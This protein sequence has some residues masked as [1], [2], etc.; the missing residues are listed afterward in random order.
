MSYAIIILIVSLL[1]IAIGFI[2]MFM[3]FRDRVTSIE[4]E[5][6]FMHKNVKAI[7]NNIIN[8]FSKIDSIDSK[9]ISI[10][11]K[12]DI[13]LQSMNSVYNYTKFVAESTTR[14]NRKVKHKKNKEQ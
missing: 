11:D 3:Y 1:L 7:N 12:A 10:D 9:T 13:L 5:V 6:Y 2:W 8:Y 14:N 4:Q